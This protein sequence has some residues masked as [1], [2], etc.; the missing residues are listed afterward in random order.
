[1]N[2]KTKTRQ[3]ALCVAVA[4][5][6]GGG[7]YL[8]NV[9]YT[10]AADVVGHN[11]LVNNPAD[12][13]LL[14]PGISGG[15]INAQSDAGNVRNNTLTMDGVSYLTGS[16]YGGVTFGTGRAEGNHLVLQNG[17]VVNVYAAGG[18]TFG[19]NAINNKVTIS[20][21]ATSASLIYAAGGVTDGASGDA[22][23]NKA[24]MQSGTASNLY[25][26]FV[27]GPNSKGS[28]TGNEVTLSGGTVGHDVA[29]GII[30]GPSATSQGTGNAAGNKVNITGGTVN[31]VTYGGLARGIGAAT[32]NKVTV[33]GAATALKDVK[34]GQT[35]TGKASSNEV[36]F[37]EAS[38]DNLIGGRVS[39]TNAAGDAAGNKVTLRSG[40]IAYDVRGG[41]IVAPTAAGHVADNTVTINNGSVGREVTGGYNMG[42]GSTERNIVNIAGGSIT[43]VVTGGHG[44]GAGK[45]SGNRVSVTGG[46]LAGEIRGGY[47]ANA[48]EASDNHVSITGGTVNSPEIYGGRS[49]NGKAIGNTATIGT[50]TV[51]GD[52]I[53]GRGKGAEGNKVFLKNTAMVNGDAIAG[54]TPTAGNAVNNILTIEQTGATVGGGVAV[55]GQT[56][57]ASGDVI[58]NQAIMQG[59]MADQLIGGMIAGIGAAGKAEGNRAE[60]SGGTVT[61]A[62]IGA[63]IEDTAA[64]GAV[65]DN[66]AVVK[67]QTA[68]FFGDIIGG[69]TKGTG[70]VTGNSATVSGSSVTSGTVIGGMS[71]TGSAESNTVS[72]K[73][74]HA[75]RI[76]GAWIDGTNA[77][78]NAIKNE[79]TIESGSVNTG[80]SG[81]A[82]AQGSTSGKVQENTLTIKGGTI[83]GN[84]VGGET[85]GSGSAV[86]NKVIVSGTATQLDDVIGGSSARGSA[87]ANKVTFQQATAAS[88][89]GGL[90]T[91]LS[92]GSVT[93][94]TVDMTS[95]TV[96]AGV[97]GGGAG[98]G[99]TV[100]KN[101]VTVAGGSA[102]GSII[103]GR[104]SGT[105]AV[106]SNEVK[107][108]GGNIH[109]NVFGGQAGGG[110]ATGN[111][112][113]VSRNVTGSIT[114]GVSANGVAHNNS[115]DIG[116]VTVTGN[117]TG[118][119]GAASNNN[120]V[121]L[122]G[123]TV[124]GTVTGGTAASGTG[125]TLT[126]KGN[127]RTGNVAGFQK[128][129][130]D[131]AA[132]I[133]MANPLLKATGSAASSDINW[134]TI[135]MKGTVP[136]SWLNRSITLMENMNGIAFTPSGSYN[137]KR[138]T[139]TA[140]KFEGILDTDTHSG[141]G[142][143]KIE[144]TSYQFKDAVVTGAASGTDTWAGRS[145]AG[146]ST[147][148]N[149]LTIT[150]GSTTNAYG[151]WTTGTG[152]PAAEKF[153]TKDNTA[154]LNAG[155]ITNLYGGYTDAAAGKATG[156]KVFV[157]GGSVTANVTGGFGGTDAT[158]NHVTV[159]GGSVGGTIRGAQSAGTAH[160][161]T[162][163]IKGGNV[164]A[165]ILGA[166]AAGAATENK[167][168]T[169]GTV[170][171]NITG[172][173]STSGAVTKNVVT[174]KGNVTGNVTGGQTTG[175][176]NA[177]TV[178]LG[179]VTIN[180][181]VTG[182]A[183]STTSNNKVNMSGTTVSGVVTGGAGSGTGNALTVKGNNRAGNI[184]GF[185]KL[186]FNL[187][188]LNRTNPMLRLTSGT[189]TNIT[190]GSIA[191]EGT[192]EPKVGQITLVE[193]SAPSIHVADYAGVRGR[194]E[195]DF[196]YDL[197]TDTQT[198]N[199]K[200]ILFDGYRFRNA[201]VTGAASGTD[202][203]AGRSRIGNSTVNNHLT[204]TGGST[205]N[206]YGG[207]TAGTGT[208]APAAQQNDTKDNT[209]TLNAGTITNLYG[210][211]TDAAAGK[212]T[213][214]KVFVNGGSVTANVTG[215]FGGTDATDNHVTVTGG[216]V[217]GTI[218]GAQSAGTA[219]KNTVE[220]KGGNV[221]AG[222]LG[223]DA[224]GA[225]TENK[226]TT[227]GTVTGNITG[228]KST[229]GAVTKNVVTIKGNVTGNVTGGQTTGAA[230]AN[231]V[232]LG[233]V[234]INGSVTG[235]AGSTT[236]N[237]KVNMS[238]TTV[239]GVVTGGA[240]SGTGNALTV[241]GNNR[242]G[243]IAGFQK[244]T[245]N[246]GNLNR[247][248]PMLRL[249]SGTA[250]NITFGSIAFEGTPEP[251]V[252]QITLVEKSAPSI[253][254]ADYA[255]VRGRTEGDFE[256]DLDTDTQ[257]AN[258]KKILFDG[259][260]FRNAV[261]TGA[262]SGTDTW[263]GR[264]RIGNST[265][266]N[267]L[268]IT[269]G[270]TTNAYGGWTA[271][272]GTTAPAA[273]Q[274]DT[275]G[276]TVTLK[277]GTVT[278]LYGGYTTSPN[279]K[280][281]GNTANV[282]GGAATNVIGGYTA[283]PTG[284]ATG[285][286][287]NINA[288][289]VGHVT[290]G[291]GAAQ[292]NANIVT[293]KANVTGS[294]VGGKSVTGTASG[295]ILTLSAVHIGGSV[296]GGQGAVTKDNEINLSGTRVAGVVTGGTA[297]SAGNKLRVLKKGAAAQSLRN[298]DQVSFTVGSNLANG[299][300]MLTL[301]GN[302]NLSYSAIVKPTGAVAGTWLGSS[303]EKNAHL[304]R[305]NGG[306]LGLTGYTHAV[307]VQRT[308]DV[309]YAVKTDNDAA[310]TA[311]SLDLSAYRWQNANVTVNTGVTN[312]FGGK[313]VIT[314]GST[315]NN[316]LKLAAGANVQTAVG[317]DT[318][319]M[320]GSA[321]K[322]VV[323]VVQG[324][325]AHHIIGGRS[326][327]GAASE[328]SVTVSGGS[329]NGSIKGAQA[330]GKAEKNT[331][332]LSGGTIHANVT[333]AQAG[334]G[335]AE[336]TV[337]VQTNVT[338]NV[339]GAQTTSGTAS[340]NTIDLGNI[341]VTGNVTG[342]RGT[343]TNN[344]TIHL[345]KTTVGGTITGGT[346]AGGTG[347]TLVVHPG[348]SKARSLAG[349]QNV[350]FYLDQT[351]DKAH[352][353]LSL[354]TTHQDLRGVKVGVGVI[355]GTVP[356]LRVNDKLSLIKVAPG[357]TLRT[358]PAMS[359]T[360]TGM[361]GV[362]LHYDFT[363]AQTTP[364]ELSAT[365]TKAML[366]EQTKSFAETR[367][368]VSDFINH[369]AD[370]LAA[371]GMNAAKVEAGKGRGYALWAM[372]DKSGMKAKT[373]SYVDTNGWNLGLG[374]ANQQKTKAGTWTFGPFVEY[375]HGSYSSYLNDGTHGR[376][377]ISYLGGGIMANYTQKNG[378][379]VEG[380]LHG[381]RARSDYSGSVYTGTVSTYDGSS[382]YYAAH[383]GVGKETRVHKKDTL[384]TY[385]RYFYSHQAGMHATLNTGE[386]YTFDSVNSH[387]L[388]L[389][390]RYSH[391]DSAY[392][393]VYAGLAFEYEFDGE[394]RASFQGY[395]TPSPSL[396]GAS[397]ML[398][399]GYRFI[400]QNGRVSYE[401]NLTG[402]QGR[403]EGISGGAQVKWMF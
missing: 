301:R 211:Y 162:V 299:D 235:G 63:Q 174:I 402:W 375:G 82:I 163:E 135:E 152:T 10:Y 331:V 178:D 185:Q 195:G 310:I 80:A 146:N 1:M 247:T 221:H 313:T 64:T 285:N 124:T 386:D 267:R 115:V 102:S 334:T 21:A 388:R 302:T 103:G 133:N 356:V 150:G 57:G 132:P 158:D 321:S 68:G 69:Q 396:K 209:A 305:M 296:T 53:G 161:N 112:V 43:D 273:Q 151:G 24:V 338:G 183:G 167:V 66:H 84:S 306:T 205:T 392:S 365:V 2:Q 182:G 194:T 220:I 282:N 89:T 354:T 320:G 104:N 91:G 330:A 40:T 181:S 309:E 318:Q 22:A 125:N 193:K 105:G 189:A 95:G 319:S 248:N 17:T 394:A 254:V 268:T 5:S 144:Y 148:N 33:S 96:T 51:S 324:A 298:F 213:G 143:R 107:L 159:T 383:L 212:A 201:V 395:N 377:K 27:L 260:R 251:K 130:F 226:V 329:V 34:G 155:T 343:T 294:V 367:A 190:F 47:A 297:G 85:A 179:A 278:N 44:T 403:R 55:G 117:V 263:A 287:V 288:G 110:A 208:T 196:E 336:N 16:V 210:G 141:V 35:S 374:W 327:G 250:T 379:W 241:K 121:S 73:E 275:T 11:V 360:T 25:G 258:A 279:G 70:A 32:T 255:G 203:W 271:G 358:D 50:I 142:V 145:I 262:A 173:K 118:G 332:L 259:Y 8:L 29:G 215:G 71:H 270:S 119:Q 12:P 269:G 231:T 207:W 108:T 168:T 199:A 308:G 371:A 253:H 389:G 381:G 36:D 283:A 252:G 7:A 165:G 369:G 351:V 228:A 60:V 127:N 284:R 200:K 236:S 222:I 280:A 184:A 38:A 90:V 78:G 191:F 257:T 223:A 359:N 37:K 26:G 307:S 3:L 397:G 67:T 227:T 240:G 326:A 6:A 186:T 147:V 291:F 314:N 46:T 139:I 157:N 137:G 349:I 52:V 355:D 79:V 61:T 192:P 347:N 202:T 246:L 399:L 214:N 59:G 261:V 172:A 277:A 94:N 350:H 380:S 398:E 120:K 49:V 116:A 229:S 376:G 293:V 111:I 372:T 218:R 387:R 311:G 289:N 188:N 274:N 114:G 93:G 373:G 176:A 98:A 230:N 219:H 393:Q 19:G 363:L 265:V 204:I 400:P 322:G 317:S 15:E 303:M 83:H 234:T 13:K 337:T 123:S 156:N 290:G 281:T 304:I 30:Q 348:A 28:A 300:T 170:T 81:A 276:N 368:G 224:A 136:T 217:G 391:K 286:I 106:S 244:L 264:S 92:T 65:K 169:T 56:R 295:N 134:R 361:Q 23:S 341:T 237:N 364:G 160:K 197:D 149:R 175:A 20:G 166:D 312:A 138:V 31:G 328:N 18:R 153:N 101:I 62:V 77:A 42:R 344:N 266:N 177:N 109:A 171:G 87:T 249:T 384:N 154:T 164:H 353:I 245:F 129:V 272:T 238:G 45:V 99:V 9:P 122:T 187:G 39:G 216:S 345:S 76:A 370:T 340:K 100:E 75:S 88:L 315:K 390:M 131:V 346:A 323:T 243:N 86:S 385:L 58:G 126:V 292:A 366:N 316:T 74:A 140:G 225:A 325:A 233:A 128:L 72:F 352:P 342:G 97:F 14:A 232:D 339:T 242:A 4:L 401:L 256:Y 198:A 382:S 48:G 239:S 113:T 335:A 206:A 180:G 54:L 362:S 41:D 357:G 378:V 333:G